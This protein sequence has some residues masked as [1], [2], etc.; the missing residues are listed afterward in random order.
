MFVRLL[1]NIDH[2]LCIIDGLDDRMLLYIKRENRKICSKVLVWIALAVRPLSLKQLGAAVG[3]ESSALTSREQAV[4]DYVKMCGDILK[5]QN[6]KVSLIHQS[7]RD[8]FSRSTIDMTPDLKEFRFD[9]EKA[10][11]QMT[12]TCL[13]YMQHTLKFTTEVNNSLRRKHPLLGYAVHFWPTHANLSNTFTDKIFQHPSGFFRERSSLRQNWWRFYARNIFIKIGNQSSLHMA[14]YS[15]VV[16]W[17][18]KLLGRER[19][20]RFNKTANRS[21]D[22]VTS[23]LI[24]AVL[25][26]HEAIAKLLLR[27]GANV[28]AKREDGSGVLYVAVGCGYEAVTRLLLDIGADINMGDNDGYTALHQAAY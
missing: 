8:Y 13:D 27:R 14:C 26:N 11:M 12:W 1:D 17:L 16:P 22:E 18:E 5:I 7:G 24:Y 2:T 25:S 10:H 21:D 4:R 3:I 15:G 20:T 19:Q 6:E 28:N 23:P 9:L